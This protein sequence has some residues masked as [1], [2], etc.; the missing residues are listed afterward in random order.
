MLFDVGIDSFFGCVSGK[1]NKV[2]INK[3]EYIKL[4]STSNQYKFPS[5]VKEITNKM[6]R[7]PT[8]REKIFANNMS[9]KG[10]IP[11]MCKEL[12]KLG[13]LKN[14]PQWSITQPLKRIHLNQF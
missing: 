13:H 11:T 6:K 1:G 7:L 12:I 3:W 2:K 14:K 8:E 10:I 5:S 4:K 9:D